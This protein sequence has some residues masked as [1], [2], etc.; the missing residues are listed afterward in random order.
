PTLR[1]RDEDRDA[2]SRPGGGHGGWRGPA[3]GASGRAGRAVRRAAAAR[4]HP[5]R[6]E[7]GGRGTGGRSDRAPARLSPRRGHLRVSVPG[8]NVVG[9]D[10]SHVL[11]PL[12]DTL[13]RGT[14]RTARGR[15][16]PGP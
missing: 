6:R 2:R 13:S 8:A 4:G 14:L 11:C 9:G 10:D 3:V 5:S 12:T 15:T 16:P 1:T 7:P